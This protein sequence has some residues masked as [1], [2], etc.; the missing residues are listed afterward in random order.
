MGTECKCANC[1]G[2]CYCDCTKKDCQCLRIASAN[3][4]VSA[5]LP[6]H[7]AKLK[8]ANVVLNASAIHANASV[9]VT[10]PRKIA[11]AVR[12]A[13]AKLLVSAKLPAH[14]AKVPNAV[15]IASAINA[16]ANA[17]IANVN[18]AANAQLKNASPALIA[19]ANLLAI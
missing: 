13:S 4:L 5:K 12:I 6:A 1:Q 3:L 8:S 7:A 19:D 9:A 14:A 11:N 2:K 16:N 10:A 18:V 17:P 15:L